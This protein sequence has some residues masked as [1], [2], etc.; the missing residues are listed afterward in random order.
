M[1][2]RKTPPELAAVVARRSDSER[3]KKWIELSAVKKTTTR[4]S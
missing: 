1:Q 3:A 2:W 4:R